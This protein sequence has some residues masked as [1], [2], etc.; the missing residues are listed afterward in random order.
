[1]S[2]PDTVL[3]LAQNW[4]AERQKRELAEQRIALQETM[5]EVAK[6]KVAY[7]D[8]V[9]QSESVYVTNQ[10]AKELGMGART[11]NRK[12]HE[13]GVQYRQNNTWLLYHRYQGK[14][15]TKTKTHYYTDSTGE[16]KTSMQTVWTE[17]GRKFIHDFFKHKKGIDNI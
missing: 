3:Q 9:L 13:F 7:F 8:K 12:L 1:M 4:K 11:L 10:I 17:R 14:G 2:N 5:I 15:F 6:P 16:T